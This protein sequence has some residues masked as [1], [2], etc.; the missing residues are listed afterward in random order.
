MAHLP[1]KVGLTGGIAGGKTTVSHL[2]A[3]LG[4][5]IIDADTIAHALVAPGQPI[6]ELISQTFG[7]DIILPN[8]QLNRTQL[9]QRVFADAKQ[10][11]ALEAILH[12]KVFQVIQQQLNQLSNIPYCVLSIPLLLETQRMDLVDRI[13]VVDCPL[14]IQRQRLI[15]HRGLSFEEIE[16]IFSV[17]VSREVRLAIANDVIYNESSL[18]NLQQQVLKLHQQYLNQQ[19]CSCQ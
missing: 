7:A 18:D 10:R 8:G 1:L 16:Q 6:L 12:P 11:Q 17:Q 19:H 14:H 2:F 9:R 5:P 15:E 13:L 3:Q 4:V